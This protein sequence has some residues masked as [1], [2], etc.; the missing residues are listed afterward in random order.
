MYSHRHLVFA[1]VGMS[2]IAAS[3]ASADPAYRAGDVVDF[4]SK[5]MKGGLTRGICVGTAQEC[6]K[7]QEPPPSNFDMLVTFNINSAEL[8]GDARANLLE[9]AKALNDPR[10]TVARFAV[11]GHTDALG[12][13]DY[14]MALSI[15]RAESVVSFLVSRGVSPDRF[16]TRGFGETAPRVD[17]PLDSV[18][19]RVETRII[20]Q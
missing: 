18:N 8:T 7:N 12:P 4:F 9:F 11:E 17:D 3:A 19:R 16:D 1:F 6:D 10:L 5:S 20:L 14:N 15:R 2:L 13:D